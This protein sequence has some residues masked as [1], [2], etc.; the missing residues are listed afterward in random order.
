MNRFHRMLALWAALL[1]L[2]IPSTAFAQEIGDL[3]DIADNEAIVANEE[4]GASLF[5]FAFDIVRVTDGIV[6]QTNLA[7]AYSSCE[8]CTTVAVAIQIVLVMGDVTTVTPENVAIAINDQCSLC[9]TFAVAYQFVVGV[10][11]G[12]IHFTGEGRK[13]L[14]QIY[15]EISKMWDDLED[16]DIE[17]EDFLIALDALMD[18]VGTILD[19][20]LVPAGKPEPEPSAS[21]SAEPSADAEPSASPSAHSDPTPS[22]EPSTTE[23]SPTPEASPTS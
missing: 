1:L 8:A 19:E 15:K 3:E 17:P 23:E 2:L 10:D 18:E 11:E 7:L 4:D 6:D 20:E 5:E 13:R 12:P 22:A 21:P 14:A 16:G 9:E